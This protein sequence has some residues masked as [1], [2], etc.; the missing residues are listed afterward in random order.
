MTGLFRQLELRTFFETSF[1]K[2]KERDL[3][4]H[5]AGFQKKFKNIPLFQSF[6]Q[7][8]T[9]FTLILRLVSRSSAIVNQNMK[10]IVDQTHILNQDLFTIRK[11]MDDYLAK[12]QQFNEEMQNVTSEVKEIHFQTRIMADKNNNIRESSDNIHKKVQSGVRTMEAGVYLIAELVEQ[13]KELNETIRDLWSKYSF[14]VAHSKDLVKISESTRMLALNAEIESAHAGEYGKGFAIVAQEMGRLAQKN[15]SISREIA[16]GIVEMQEQAKLTEINVSSSVELAENSER[17]IQSANQTYVDVSTSITKVLKDSNDFLESFS[18]LELS[19]KLITENLNSTNS[20]LSDSNR[21]VN[22]ISSA[23]D[24]QMKTVTEID[25]R[26]LSTF[27]ASRILNSLIS[28]FAIPGFKEVTPKVKSVEKLIE[29]ILNIR[30][31][32]ITGLFVESKGLEENF[33][34]EKKEMQSEINTQIDLLQTFISTPSDKSKINEF[35]TWWNEFQTMSEN[36]TAKIKNNELNSAR[37]IYASLKDKISPA[38][39]ILLG[40]VIQE[41]IDLNDKS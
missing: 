27:T 41:I 35:Q 1:K 21:S 14:L 17:E 24:S 4:I 3:G 8:F 38:L 16:R 15:S 7:F 30:G 13:N 33:Y 37:E 25:S 32:L 20:L 40:F 11:I 22:Q 12:M 26:T 9:S 28:Q 23:L 19:M 39:T 29:S 2:L 5:L 31:I 36:C 18:N 10:Q 6:I 34:H